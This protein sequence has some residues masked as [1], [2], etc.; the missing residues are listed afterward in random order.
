MKMKRKEL[1][2]CKRLLISRAKDAVLL[3]IVLLSILTSQ[4]VLAQAPT[5]SSSPSGCDWDEALNSPLADCVVVGMISCGAAAGCSATCT[6]VPFS[7]P[8]CAACIAG[9]SGWQVTLGPQVKD[10]ICWASGYGDYNAEA[11]QCDDPGNEQPQKCSFAPRLPL[12]PAPS[13]SQSPSSN[14][15]QQV[16]LSEEE[17]VTACNRYLLGIPEAS[18]GNGVL[19]DC[20][21]SCVT[22]AIARSQMRRL[23]CPNSTS[24][25]GL[26]RLPR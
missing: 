18:S 22:E 16:S 3:S 20:M 7:L 14:S 2:C 26:R 19:A 4:A 12:P 25:P 21:M 10:C 17:I 6:A 11:K 23:P 5:P 13:C 15:S 9:T 8:L 24:T 1:F